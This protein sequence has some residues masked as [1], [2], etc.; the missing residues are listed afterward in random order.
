MNETPTR[1]RMVVVD[2]RDGFRGKVRRAPSSET[3]PSVQSESDQFPYEWKSRTKVELL[4]V[5]SESYWKVSK[6]CSVFRRSCETI[7]VTSEVRACE[8]RVATRSKRRSEFGTAF[9][10][11]FILDWFQRKKLWRCLPATRPVLGLIVITGL[12]LDCCPS[13]VMSTTIRGWSDEAGNV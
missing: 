8:H 5:R 7:T 6:P 13:L 4:N 10:F 1:A 11:Y 12:V 9:E 2:D 3:K